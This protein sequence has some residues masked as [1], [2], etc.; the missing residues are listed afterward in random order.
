MKLLLQS[1]SGQSHTPPPCWFMRQAGRYLPEY[2][3]LRAKAGGFLNLVYNPEL[4]SEVTLQPIRRF[5]MDGAILFSDI[6]VVPHALG[7]DVRFETGE[8][9]VVEKIVTAERIAQMSLARVREHC[10]PIAETIRLTKAQLPPHVT[11]LGFAGAPWTVACYMVEGKGTK[12]YAGARGFAY[13]NSKIFS[14]L[15]DTLVD[16]TIDYLSMQIE[17][18]AEALQL[19]DSWAGVLSPA[20]FSQWVSEPNAR[21]VAALKDMHPSIPIIAFPRGAGSNLAN[22]AARVA[23]DGISVDYNT[24]IAAVRAALPTMC[25][26]GN[27]DPLVVASDKKAMLQQATQILESMR[28]TPFIFNLGHGFVPHTPVENVEALMEKIR[29]FA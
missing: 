17:A 29:S 19:F 11:M 23:C 14:S 13:E 8:G 18:G 1:L 9:P 20:Q 3:E 22:F 10:A 27:L 16:A 15:I 4:A 5:G 21:I 28:G 12:D 26:Q 7:V 25:L 24:D 6:L 2:R